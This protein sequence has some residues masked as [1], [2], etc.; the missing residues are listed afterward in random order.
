MS[1]TA[2]VDELRAAAG[3]GG[4]R[5]EHLAVQQSRTAT[6]ADLDGFGG[7]AM[8][9]LAARLIQ[10]ADD[11]MASDE[12]ASDAAR[13]RRRGG[14]CSARR[15]P[16]RTRGLRSCGVH[17]GVRALLRRRVSAGWRGVTRAPSTPLEQSTLEAHSSREVLCGGRRRGS[18]GDTAAEL[19]LRSKMEKKNKQASS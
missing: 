6:L 18:P 10:G 11:Q 16:L 3:E 15:P 8:P 5:R 4:A 7:H 17:C 12:M 1:F 14:C 9:P 2:F 13:P 19:G